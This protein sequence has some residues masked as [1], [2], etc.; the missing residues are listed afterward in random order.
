MNRWTHLYP[1][2]AGRVL[3]A[4]TLVISL[5]QYFMTV[6]GISQRNLTTMEKS[7]RLFIWNGKKGQLAWNRAILPVKEGGISAPSVKIRY[8]TVKVGWLK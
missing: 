1:S 7:I 8:E 4:K 3:L 5:A 6:N 2:V